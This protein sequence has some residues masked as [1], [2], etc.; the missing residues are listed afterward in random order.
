LKSTVKFVCSNCGYESSKWL[1][2]CPECNNWNSFE[3]QQVTF[4][5]IKK[6]KATGEIK[7]QTL[8]EVK[9]EKSFRFKTGIAELDRVL[10]G[11]VVRGSS[12]LIGGEPGIGK[13][14]LMLQTV[15]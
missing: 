10:G 14:T 5:G 7:I 6:S 3:E 1:G 8:S 15:S 11:G 4:A 12:V 2:R 13:S 9:M